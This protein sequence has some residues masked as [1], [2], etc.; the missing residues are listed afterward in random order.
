MTTI[1]KQTDES[2]NMLYIKHE[3]QTDIYA[4]SKDMTKYST[5][6]HNTLDM[7]MDCNN[8]NP[9]IVK[10]GEPKHLEFVINYMTKCLEEKIE[11]QAP[12]K[13]LKS[14]HLSVILGD[15]YELFNNLV[16]IEDFPNNIHDMHEYM[17]VADYLGCKQL[18]DKFSS[19]VAHILMNQSI[20]KLNAVV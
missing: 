19:I 13:P 15:E 2:K 11:K 6:L 5:Y 17:K 1:K 7:V 18:F 8:T 9:I 4:I 10:Q 14:V 16:E 3:K 12:E 20:E